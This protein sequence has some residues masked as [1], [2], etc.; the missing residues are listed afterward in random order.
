MKNVLAA[1]KYLASSASIRYLLR[2]PKD[3]Q[4]VALFCSSR[5][6]YLRIDSDTKKKSINKLIKIDFLSSSYRKSELFVVLDYG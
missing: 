2:L 6:V 4:T 3:N 5:T 1:L